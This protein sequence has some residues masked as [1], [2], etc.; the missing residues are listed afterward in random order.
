MSKCNTMRGATRQVAPTGDPSADGDPLTLGVTITLVLM[1]VQRL[2]GFLRQVLVCRLLPPE[3]LGIWN[4]ASSMLVLAAPLLVLGVPGTFGRYAEYFRRRGQ[5]RS[6]FR[7]TTWGTILLA[8]SGT[9]ALAIMAGPVAWLLFGDAQHTSLIWQ[10]TLT[11][12]TVIVF[13]YLVELFTSLR[14]VRI[15]SA[16]RFGNSLVFAV[17]A[18]LLLCCYRRSVSSLLISYAV[19]CVTSSLVALVPLLSA[20]RGLET[21]HHPLPWRS[22]CAKVFPFA[23]WI[24]LGDLLGNLFCAADRY[25]IVHFAQLG[26]DAAASLVGQYHS[27][28]IIPELMVAVAVLLAPI[29]LPYLTRDWERGDGGSV[30]RRLN[31]L[32]KLYSLG[33][34]VAGLLLILG[35][36]WMFDWALGG[37]YSEGMSV[38]PLTMV[39]CIW[40][41]MF[42]IAQNYLLCAERAGLASVSLLC[43]LAANVAL[44]L[45][46]LP[47]FGLHGAVAATT[48]GNAMSL[49]LVYLFARWKRMQLDMATCLATAMP[50]CLLLGATPGCVAVAVLGWLGIH[51]RLLFDSEEIE[52]IAS[53]LRRLWDRTRWRVVSGG[54]PHQ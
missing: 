7:Q 2:V 51:R 23:G 30:S 10:L 1:V 43:G 53:R 33:M 41:G 50:T 39:S 38:M 26:P 18:L 27:S 35:A 49:S 11:L 24:W 36:P 3:E 13:N 28:R 37:K 15:V 9:L 40:F 29:L 25:M 48:A 45:V 54:W 47:P 34:T 5:L 44:N 32:L 6:F 21:V 31:Q 52:V 8:G 22:L 46:L 20:W 42:V 17:L 4:L 12:V 14:H 19:A 16:M